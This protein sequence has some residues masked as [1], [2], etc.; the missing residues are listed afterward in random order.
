MKQANN[1]VILSFIL[2]TISIANE[3]ICV[4]SIN[5]SYSAHVWSRKKEELARKNS[6]LTEQNITINI[7]NNENQ[8]ITK[9]SDSDTQEGLGT[10]ESWY[11]GG[12]AGTTGPALITKKNGFTFYETTGTCSITYKNGM[13]GTGLC[14]S[15]RTI[16]KSSD[17][18]IN[19]GP[20]SPQLL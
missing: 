14:Y 13:S 3:S 9:I 20:E 7:T 1:F 5:F 18:E 19:A 8:N 2:P 17:I 15:A 12:V 4:D 11:L 16:G 6:R 10:K